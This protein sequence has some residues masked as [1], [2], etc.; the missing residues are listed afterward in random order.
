[1]ISQTYT[2]GGKTFAT[3]DEAETFLIT[4]ARRQRIASLVADL[5]P[6]AGW[7]QAAAV[8]LLEANPRT[9]ALIAA[10]AL[11]GRDPAALDIPADL[12]AGLNGLLAAELGIELEVPA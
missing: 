12:A 11:L 8:E 7:G 1:L 3:Q 2:V 10:A 6:P 5:V 9:C 4:E